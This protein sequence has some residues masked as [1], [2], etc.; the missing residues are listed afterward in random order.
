MSQVIVASPSENRLA[1]ADHKT[2]SPARLGPWELLRLAGAGS[3][4]QVYQ[5]TPAGVPRER[6]G[7]YAL[8]MPAPGRETDAAAIA[9][10]RQEAMAARAVNHPHVVAILSASLREPP[11]YLVMPWLDGATL[12]SRLRRSGPL[13]W[14]IA[15]WIARQV[16]SGLDALARALWIHGDVKP[17]NIFLSPD[18]HATLLD[19]GFARAIGAAHSVADR[20]ILGTPSY[21]APELLT[22]SASAGISSD[23]Y[24]LGVVLYEML[25]GRLPFEAADLGA[26]VAAHRRGPPPRLEK[27]APWLPRELAQWVS[28]MLANDPLRRPAPAELVRRFTALEIA[29]LAAAGGAPGA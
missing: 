19:L 17:S 24:S 2:G 10:L 23:V 20:C 18:G 25:V 27:Q 16:T 9:L 8:K 15:V 3:L 11:Y 6:G 22:R 4:S 5:A 7:A 1:R 13:D 28:R 14:R 29:A 12:Q 26:M 21:M